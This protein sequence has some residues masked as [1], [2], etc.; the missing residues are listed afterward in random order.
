[1]S[2]SSIKPK[3]SLGQH[4]LIDDNIIRKII[5]TF[6]CKSDDIV[7]EIGPGTGALTQFLLDKKCILFAIEKDNI[8]FELLLN[9]FPGKDYPLLT[10]IQD[11]I[12]NIK[13]DEIIK[14]HP[15]KKGKVTVIGNIPYNISAD[16]LF[17]LCE[18]AGSI[19]KALIMVQK[20]VAKR[21]T[22]VSSTKD[23][24]ITTIA[25][26]LVGKVSLKFDISPNCFYPPPKVVSSMLEI[27]FNET[28]Y[29]TEYFYSILELVKSAFNQRRK[30]L[31]NAL[32]VYFDLNLFDTEK[33]IQADSK[34]HISELL[35]KRAEQ[36]SMNDFI[37]LHSLVIEGNKNN[38]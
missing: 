34:N 21:I 31:R 27:T 13:I 6:D 17:W 28:Q 26:G 29:P 3:K 30:M 38:V 25:V 33:I 20:E 24:G 8:A 9:K 16:I 14:N 12:R 15:S 4:F 32:K 11:D 5:N 10:L 35:S 7:I 36:L 19:S 1:M 37:F 23:Y 2:F 18:Q 22:A